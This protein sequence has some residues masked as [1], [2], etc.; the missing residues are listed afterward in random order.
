[1]ITLSHGS[2]TMPTYN[3]GRFGVSMDAVRV[4]SSLPD[5]STFQ[6]ILIGGSFR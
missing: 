6:Q 2:G 1:M 4:Y 3:M 5:I